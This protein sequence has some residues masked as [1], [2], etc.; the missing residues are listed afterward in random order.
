MDCPER[1][2][3]ASVVKAG[4]AASTSCASESVGRGSEQEPKPEI[5]AATRWRPWEAE[6]LFLPEVVEVEEAGEPG[7]PDWVPREET[8]EEEEGLER[9]RRKKAEPEWPDLRLRRRPGVMMAAEALLPSLCPAV[10]PQ[11]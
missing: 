9:Q 3:T 7:W 5:W 4:G 2:P 6:D 8:A 11:I 10:E 1:F